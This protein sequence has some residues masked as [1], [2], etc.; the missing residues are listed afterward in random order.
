MK[1]VSSG[2]KADFHIHS[3]YSRVKDG[4]KVSYNTI[5]NIDVLKKKLNENDVQ[6]C[7][8]TDHD[9]FGYDIYK[10]LKESETDDAS[11]I[12]KVFPGVEF[13]VQFIGDNKLPTVLHVIAIFNDEDDSRIAQIPSCISGMDGKPKYDC[14]Q[15]FSEAMF[16]SILRDIDLDTVLIVH[17]KN[18][19]SSDDRKKH[20]ANKVGDD[21]FRE[22]IYTDYFEAFEFRNRRNEVFN[23][24]FVAENNLSEKMTFVTGSDCHDWRIY[25]KES[26]KDDG[27]FVFSYFKCLPTFRGLVMAITDHRRIRTENNFFNSTGAF[28]PQIELMINKVKYDL[29][30][31]RGINVVIGDN[32]IGKSLLLHHLTRYS[33]LKPKNIMAGYKK[34]LLSKKTEILSE[35]PEC[36]LFEFDT[37]GG[38]RA[39]FEKTSVKGGE[40]LQKYYPEPIQSEAYKEKVQRQLNKIYEYLNEKFSIEKLQNQLGRFTIIS[41]D[42]NNAESLSFIGSVK[43]NTKLENGY[44]SLYE[45]LN[46]LIEKIKTIRA[47]AY[48]EIGDQSVLDDIG[49]R[50]F[51]LAQK[52]NHKKQIVSNE[53]NRI[54]L[55]QSA[56]STFKQSYR[57]QVSET[58]KSLSEYNERITDA[59]DRIV[60]IIQRTEKN[61]RPAISITKET[62]EGRSTRVFDYEFNSRLGII[63]ISDDYIRNLFVGAFKKGVRAC[64][65]NM[66]S[67]ELAEA[68]PYYQEGPADALEQLKQKIQE[69][70]DKDF[71]NKFTITQAGKDRTEELSTGFNA[72]TYFDIMSYETNNQGI[73]IIDQPEDNISQKAIREYL[74]DRF[75]TMG[76]NRQVIIVTHNPQFIVNLDVDNVI[77]I[78][79]DEKD[80]LQIW[81]GA[82]EYK[83]NNYN[84]LDIISTNIEGGLDTLKRRWKRY[85]KNSAV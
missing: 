72:Q 10:K 81:S 24:H 77:F 26:G 38:I 47:N 55:Y 50:V 41:N 75:K 29:P 9:A 43:K 57:I 12:V 14:G 7:A 78:G 25:P 62:I 6:L 30:L 65:L 67:Q 20:D 61:E 42:I 11:S 70:V 56:I 53:N 32:S 51:N 64:V 35:I 49:D 39:K 19:L 59:A 71:V 66:T 36:D 46:G 44:S 73:Y 22:F 28:L 60:E 74:L 37:Q 85:E 48:I 31:S 69:Q 23:K 17:Q 54:A 83:D 21:K 1:I 80:Q 2:F 68:M 5:E 79:K 76:E 16:L 13:S 45:D 40:Y 4:K 82:L 27:E 84:I 18:S 15:A 34:Y 8:I 63:E 3:V 52:Y 33:R 58:Q